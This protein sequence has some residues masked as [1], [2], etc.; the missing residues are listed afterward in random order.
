MQ[1]QEKII[2]CYD[3]VAENYAAEFISELSNKH[4]DRLILKAFAD[5]NRNKGLF[6][7]FG[8]GPGQTTKFLYDLGV[9]DVVGIDLSSGMIKT[10]SKLF[11]EIKFEAGDLLN[12]PYS[13]GYFCAGI[14]F[15]AVVHFTY[16][17]L[18]LAFSEIHKVLKDEGQFLFS[19]HVG[20]GTVHCDTFLEKDVDIDFYYFDTEK[21]LDI[22][23][24]CGFKIIDAVERKP[25]PDVE[26]PST[27]AYVWIEKLPDNSNL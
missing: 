8:C 12:L 10:A 1:E 6:A 2:K 26:Y 14:A 16:D 11:P 3:E 13:R 17:Q 27:R 24:K 23:G 20:E 5:A 21:V 4:F 9:K 7:D 25:Y 15:Y 19:F 18:K 22:V